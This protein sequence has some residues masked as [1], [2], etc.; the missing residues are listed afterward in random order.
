[1]NVK[2]AIEEFLLCKMA[3]GL[4]DSTITWYK[5][6]FMRFDKKF[7]D[8]PLERLNINDLRKYIVDIRSEN[9]SDDYKFALVRVVRTLLKW[10][11]EDTDYRNDMY[12]KIKPHPRSKKAPKGV[13]PRDVQRLLDSCDESVSSIRDF[14]II[15][16]LYDTGCRA[17]GLCNL[18]LREL[19]LDH[20]RAL[21]FEKGDKTRVVLFR[22]ETAN[23][24]ARWFRVRKWRDNPF[25]FHSLQEDVPLNPT[26]LRHMLN[27]RGKRADVKGKVNPHAF[28][29][30]F[31]REYILNGGD[32]ASASEIM[33]HSSLAVTKDF[34]A[35]FSIEELREKHDEFS[36]LGNLEIVA[37]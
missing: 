21:I 22:E 27:R 7:G 20:R 35:M 15:L 13:D 17:A 25:V 6:R 29:H 32:L 30:G 31:A 16:F 3:E 12:K 9:V 8:W 28:R 5:V 23:A 14:S 18:T 19:D 36:P 4:K 11:N 26:S 24:L 1:M 10:C 34:Y 2:E 33:G 37:S